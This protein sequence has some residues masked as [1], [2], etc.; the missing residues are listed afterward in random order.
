MAR[1]IY[2]RSE[3]CGNEVAYV[4]EALAS[5][6]IASHGPFS[7]RCEE[8]LKREFGPR[9]CRL[10]QSATA[11]LEL[12]TLLVDAGPRDEVILPSF[13]YVACANAI[14]LRGATPVFADINPNTLNLDPASIA[15]AIAPATR[16]IMTVHYAGVPCAM[17]EIVSLA[18]DHKLLVIEDAAQAFLSQYRSRPAGTLGDLGIFSFHGT[19]NVTC[20]E[21]GALLVNSPALFE[22][23]DIA[24]RNG[25]DRTSYERGL[26]AHYTW[27]GPGSSFAPSEIT[28]AVL[29]AQLERAHMIT[30]QRRALW[31][32]Y[33]AAFASAERAGFV[34]RP[35][36]PEGI[37]HNGHIYYLLL[38]TGKIRD[39]FIAMM[40]AAGIVTPFHYV[41]LHSSPA[42]R[43][44]G[45]TANGASLHQTEDL[46]G[47]LV[48]LPL[49]SGIADTQE[50][51]IETALKIIERIYL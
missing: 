33:H 21:G 9:T 35:T 6:Q 1:I 20:G 26:R 37:T 19:K 24:H 31:E 5:G 29:L 15:A 14:V 8:W 47:R 44:Y 34:R 49:W 13:T 4:A 45:R 48:R 22:K 25:T 17:D 43:V 23:A 2:S 27:V 7:Q 50:Q 11:A 36:I 3:T 39:D 28:A 32:R 10:T 46:A 41:P 51:I 38:R 42:G 18:K 30:E 16:A 40:Q 12:A